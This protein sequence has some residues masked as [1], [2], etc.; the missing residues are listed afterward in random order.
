MDRRGSA[1]DVCAVLR[2]RD[3]AGL[4]SLNDNPKGVMLLVL[5]VLCEWSGSAVSVC[6]Y[7]VAMFERLCIALCLDCKVEWLH[8]LDEH[9][10][11]GR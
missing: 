5:A 1:I 3:G 7:L 6:S 9:V 2:F 4:I 10:L 8:V 11:G